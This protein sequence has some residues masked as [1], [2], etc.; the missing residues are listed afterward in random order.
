MLYAMICGTVPYKGAN[1]QEL[2]E[3]ILTK[4]IS[5]T[6]EISDDAKDLISN[7]LVI[8]PTD[9]LSIPEILSHPFLKSLNDSQDIESSDHDL[10]MGL[11]FSR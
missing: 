7:M 3:A 1:L 11:S 9:R 5:Y 4:K 6:K 10:K 2:H 8:T